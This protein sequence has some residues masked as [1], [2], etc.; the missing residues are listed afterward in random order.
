MKR[1]GAGGLAAL[2]A[3]AAVAQAQEQTTPGAVVRFDLSQR[4]EYS[5]NPDLSDPKVSQSRARTTLG[6]GVTSDT[7]ISRFQFDVRSD[8]EAGAGRETGFASPRL[9]LSYDRDVGN[10]RMG[11]ALSFQDAA[12]NSDPTST[13]FD[14]GT[15]KKLGLDLD[16]ETGVNAPI[17]MEWAVAHDSQRYS[18]TTDPSLINNTNNAITS[19]VYFRFDPRMTARVTG[20][21]ADYDVKGLGTDRRTTGFGAGL[22]LQIDKL[23]RADLSAS[24]DKVRLTGVTN[25]IEEGVSVGASLSREMPRGGLSL[26]LASSIGENGRRESA[27]LR[28]QIDLPRGALA[29]SAGSTRTEGLGSNPLFGIDYTRDLPRG[30]FSV[31]LEQSVETDTSTQEEINSSLRISHQTEINSRS[32]LRASATLYDSNELGTGADDSRRMD[33]SL[34]YERQI[35]SDWDMVAG[36][37]HTKSRSDSATDRS[38]NTVFVGLERSLLWRP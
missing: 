12:I 16:L 26:T 5:D 32:N 38:N 33:I 18:G 7:A 11:A 37:S 1:F 19:T 9:S 23:W 31:S 10:A 35:T 2:C 4:L 25:R 24:R 29:L 30:G 20:E 27:I 36:I 17:G 13:T 3:L 22:E 28:R 34:T 14:P 8:L 15:N 21:Y 6:I